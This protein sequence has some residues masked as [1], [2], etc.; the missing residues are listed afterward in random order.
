MLIGTAIGG[1]NHLLCCCVL[2]IGRSCRFWSTRPTSI[3]IYIYTRGL[4][5]VKLNA[6]CVVVGKMDHYL[7]V[8]YHTIMEGLHYTVSFF[9]PWPCK[10]GLTSIIH[11]NIMLVRFPLLFKTQHSF[12]VTPDYQGHQH[13]YISKAD[14]TRHDQCSRKHVHVQGSMSI[15]LQR[16]L[17]KGSF[18]SFRYINRQTHCD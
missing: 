9:P 3:Y 12:V 18:F 2:M 6:G 13:D 16:V 10:V 7:L 14:R 4:F 11:F 17:E 5:P 15:I 1:L 8:C